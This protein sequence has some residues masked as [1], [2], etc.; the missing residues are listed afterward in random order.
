MLVDRVLADLDM[1]QSDDIG[2]NPIRGSR[3]GRCA[4]QSAYMLF[5]NAYPP[6]P[7][8]A[9]TRLVF[10]FGDLIHELVREQF[11]RVVPGQ[12]GFEEER[13]HFKVPLTVKEAKAAAKLVNDGALRATVTGL[14]SLLPPVAVEIPPSPVSPP[15]KRGLWL[16]LAEPALYV[17]L[18]VDGIADAGPLGLIP[19]EIKSM[20][21]I[22]FRYALAGKL[23]YAYRVQMATAV[24]ATEADAV[25]YVAVRKDTC[26]LLE[27]VYSKKADKISVTFTKQGQMVRAITAPAEGHDDPDSASPMDDWE[28]AQ[29]EHPFEPELLEEARARVRRILLATPVNLPAREHLPSFDCK[30]CDGT[31]TQTRAKN[32]GLP[33]KKAKECED[34]E[35]SEGLMGARRRTGQLAEAELPWQCRYCPSIVHCWGEANPDLRF[36]REA[37]PHFWITRAAYEGMTQ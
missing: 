22:G 37:K 8:P 1:P 2:G 31:G 12:W 13:F 32:T 19:A 27:V 3:L 35:T 23:D 15:H 11:R 5:P 34:C 6:E 29:V 25:L 33:L 36:D 9:R 16:D 7:L 28:A 14:A 26:H 30:R 17:P 20:T 24:D 10:R 18:H 21:T 4:R